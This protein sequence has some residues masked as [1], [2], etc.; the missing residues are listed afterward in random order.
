MGIFFEE[1]HTEALHEPSPKDDLM[2]ESLPYL[3]RGDS[4]KYLDQF[5]AKNEEPPV[6]S[7]HSESPKKEEKNSPELDEE[8]SLS[9]TGKFNT[10]AFHNFQKHLTVCLK[11][12][13]EI[14]LN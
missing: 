7:S 3:Q 11:N 8:F 13:I 5:F 6:A 4:S 9:S 10:S 12:S 2:P 14:K 1:K